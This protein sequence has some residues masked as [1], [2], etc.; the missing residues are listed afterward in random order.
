[1]PFTLGSFID[2]QLDDEPKAK[3]S[4]L[5]LYLGDVLRGEC[6][7]AHTEVTLPCCLRYA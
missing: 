6:P 4:A 3:L 5:G 2:S 1:M 7:F